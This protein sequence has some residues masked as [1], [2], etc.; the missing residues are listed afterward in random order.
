M[1]ESREA[2]YLKP[3][4]IRELVRLRGFEAD[5]DRRILRRCHD[6]DDLRRA[7]QRRLPRPVFGYA[8]GA[9]DEELTLRA[10]RAALRRWLR[11]P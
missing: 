7:A 8:D 2:G 4:E 9:A 10:N 1:H 6:L 5:R 11:S 3:R